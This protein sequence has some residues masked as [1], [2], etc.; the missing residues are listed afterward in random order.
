MEGFRISTLVNIPTLVNSQGD[1]GWWSEIATGPP[2]GSR[3]KKKEIK[4]KTAIKYKVQG[5]M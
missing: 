5:G 1:S 3:G 2:D 4:S